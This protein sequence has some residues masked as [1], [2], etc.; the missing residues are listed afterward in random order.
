M[1]SG[2]AGSAFKDL[3]TIIGLCTGK[4]LAAFSPEDVAAAVSTP[5]ER[6]KA[7]PPPAAEL[8]AEQ[9]QEDDAASMS[10][11][12]ASDAFFCLVMLKSDPRD[13]RLLIC[14]DDAFQERVTAWDIKNNAKMCTKLGGNPLCLWECPDLL[15]CFAA[16][17]DSF[18][19]G[20]ALQSAAA[21]GRPIDISPSSRRPV[22]AALPLAVQS[23]TASAE[24]H[25][26]ARSWALTKALT[27]R[28]KRWGHPALWLVNV[29]LCIERGLRPHLLHP[30]GL[31][32]LRACVRWHLANDLIFASLTAQGNLP[33][34]SVPV[35]V[36]AWFNLAAPMFDYPETTLA[37]IS[38]LDELR[39][40]V[41][42]AGFELPEGGELRLR[43]LRL[44]MSMRSWLLGRRP[45]GAGSFPASVAATEADERKRLRNLAVALQFTCLGVLPAEAD[46]ARTRLPSEYEVAQFIRCDGPNGSR[47]TEAQQ[48]RV[49]AQL[50]ELHR[51]YVQERGV[52]EY[53]AL[54]AAVRPQQELAVS[55]PP[56]DLVVEPLLDSP[57]SWPGYGLRKFDLN[58]VKLH[59]ATGRPLLCPQGKYWREHLDPADAFLSVQELVGRFLVK[60]QKWGAAAAT[61]YPSRAEVLMELHRVVLA[62][63]SKPTAALPH[64]IGQFIGETLEGIRQLDLPPAEFARRFQAS[65]RIENRMLLEW[66]ES[67]QAVEEFL[68]MATNE[69][70]LRPV[71]ILLRLQFTPTP[72]VKPWLNLL[73]SQKKTDLASM[74][75][76]LATRTD[77]P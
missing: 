72:S 55:V 65:L 49:T 34:T 71:D 46:V 52:A 30:E 9:E 64:Q 16:S 22:L 69:P 21:S 33:P 50:P 45:H 14:G 70:H 67:G 39:W 32:Q 42:V 76:L 18:I 24:E 74:V 59:Q 43:R 5:E 8:P 37:N 12:P 73:R 51:L 19:S 66:L 1:H 7:V 28:R 15:A 44:V 61:T 31:E 23:S 58:V 40:M 56:K 35:G 20:E 75:A 47:A 63:E 10:T 13:Q 68:D 4:A 25:A 3:D 53:V 54:L 57:L 11:P 29:I 27:T 41:G 36:A 26:A 48:Q 60:R 77:H 62:H 2:L 6:A 17:L 38:Y